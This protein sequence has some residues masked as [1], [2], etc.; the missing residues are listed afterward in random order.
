VA[1]L[2][3]AGA[4]VVDQSGSAEV[5]L[6]RN[7][8]LSRALDIVRKPDAKPFDVILMVDDDMVF[9]LRAAEVVVA[10]AR[11]TGLPVSA[12]YA[13]ANGRLPFE[14]LASGR[15]MGGLGF[16]AVPVAALV[17]LATRSNV[18]STD[19]GAQ[20]WEFTCSTSELRENG[21]G[22]RWLPEDYRLTRAFGGV[23]L[24]P[25]A[26][27]HLKPKVVVPERSAFEALINKEG[28]DHGE[29]NADAP[30]LAH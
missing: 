30:R 10:H 19:D 8:A 5:S 11:A 2:E 25:L 7:L 13:L 15:F 9:S 14:R 27:G 18:I 26:I 12:C 29:R 24:L 22:R 1:A 3:A 4:G 21:A 23:D 28:D 16:V 6:A 20:F 17:S